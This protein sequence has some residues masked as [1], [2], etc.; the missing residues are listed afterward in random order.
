MLGSMNRNR[1]TLSAMWLLLR[2]AVEVVSPTNYFYRPEKHY[3][4][5]PGPKT[6]SMIGRRLRAETANVTQE[7][8]PQRWLELI[9]SLDEQ[10][11]WPAQDSSSGVP[12]PVPAT[13]RKC[14]Y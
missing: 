9:Q 14:E 12:R 11:R 5:G 7:P 10:D 2:K 8:L 13:T 3:M 1:N 4:R 6:L